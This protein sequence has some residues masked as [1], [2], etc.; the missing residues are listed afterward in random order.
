MPLDLKD[1]LNWLQP[2]VI[3]LVSFALREAR[4]LAKEVRLVKARQYRLA[5]H[6]A[7]KFGD[8][9]PDYMEE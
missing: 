6:V 7:G 5:V 3:L 1:V 4:L 9:L 2:I 8:P